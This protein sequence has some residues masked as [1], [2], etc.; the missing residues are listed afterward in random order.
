MPDLVYRHDDVFFVVVRMRII[1][2][3]EMDRIVVVETDL[4]T[5]D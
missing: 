4:V 2:K 5:V 1:Q 3:S